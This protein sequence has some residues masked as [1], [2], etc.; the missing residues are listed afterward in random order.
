MMRNST[1]AD[2]AGAGE[3]EV[4]WWRRKANVNR[5]P[6]SGAGAKPSLLS[7]PLPPIGSCACFLRPPLSA[8]RSALSGGLRLSR[9]FHKFSLVSSFSFVRPLRPR[10]MSTSADASSASPSR[11][12]TAPA[13]C[14][15]SRSRTSLLRRRSTPLRSRGQTCSMGRGTRSARST[16]IVRVARSAQ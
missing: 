5:G 8:Q 3:G 9:V 10:A 15:I 13:S 7:L 1:W 4:P 6:R 2:M 11:T 14:R 16:N 12:H